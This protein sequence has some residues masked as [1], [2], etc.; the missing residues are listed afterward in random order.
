M[1]EI[2]AREKNS[3]WLNLLLVIVMTSFQDANA[4]IDGEIPT[5]SIEQY[6]PSKAVRLESVWAGEIKTT[7]HRSNGKELKFLQSPKLLNL[8]HGKSIGSKRLLFQETN[9]NPI[10]SPLLMANL[11]TRQQLVA[12]KTDSDIYK[13]LE[14]RPWLCR[15]KDSVVSGNTPKPDRANTQKK[16]SDE[17]EIQVGII[18]SNMWVRFSINESGELVFLSAYI[19]FLDTGQSEREIYT[20]QLREGILKKKEKT[21]TKPETGTTNVNKKKVSGSAGKIKAGT[22]DK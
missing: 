10:D 20:I 14:R 15:Y 7:Y 11:P 21:E 12:C 17:L 1:F 9:Y 5:T 16:L 8:T 2:F 6:L 22:T 18:K 4:Q 13:Y 3:L 19:S